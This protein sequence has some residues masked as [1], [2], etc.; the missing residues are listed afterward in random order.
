MELYPAATET[1]TEPEVDIQQSTTA[2]EEGTCHHVLAPVTIY[3]SS[4]ATDEDIVAAQ[5]RLE[6]AMNAVNMEDLQG[7]ANGQV[8]QAGT[9]TASRASLYSDNNSSG[10]KVGFSMVGMLGIILV[11]LVAI[12]LAFNRK[13]R[14]ARAT[15]DFFSD[16]TE[17]DGFTDD[18]TFVYPTEDELLGP[19]VCDEDE[20]SYGEE[21]GKGSAFIL[22]D[23]Q[24]GLSYDG[25]YASSR[26]P[27]RF[28]RSAP[29]PKSLH[30][31]ACC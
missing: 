16:D 17:N 28:H 5:E 31:K 10:K 22:E 24:D 8:S 20:L 12:K 7:V 23:L 4:E 18:G 25:S 1:Y 9:F 26:V 30:D 15:K 2:S 6:E 21:Y 19:E 11:S 3:H 27:V 29:T 14:R 13:K